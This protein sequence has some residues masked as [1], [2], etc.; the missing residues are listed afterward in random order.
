[1]NNVTLVG[2]LSGDP[3]VR[4]VPDGRA[5]AKFS[6]AVNRRISKNGEG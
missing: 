4:Y 6:V 3:E 1:M 5:I 2:N